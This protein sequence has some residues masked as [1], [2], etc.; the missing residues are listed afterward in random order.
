MPTNQELLQKREK[1]V[2]RGVVTAFPIFADKAQN[3]EIWDVEGKR[4]IDFA[5]GIGVMNTGHRHPKVLEAIASQ[6]QKILHAAFQVMGY[7][8]YIQLA[9]KLNSL[10]PISGEKKSIFFSTGAE[11]CEN[12][13]KIAR[14]ATKR[15]GMISFTGGFH[16]RT[17]MAMALTGKVVPYKKNM[18]PM[19]GDVFHVPFPIPY[20]GTTEKDSLKAL[21]NLFKADIEPERVA[22]I[23]IEP[24]QGEGGFYIAS[25]SFLKEL[26]KVCDTHGILLISDE[27]Q[28]GFARTGK[29]F[30]IEHSGVEPDLIT[31]AKSLAGGLPLSGV[32]GKA[33]IM[34]A[35]EPGGLGGTYGGNPVACAAALAIIDLIQEEK[36][37]E[38]SLKIGE[39]IKTRI[40][41]IA[42]HNPIIG[43]VRGL[44]GMVAFEV[45]ESQTPPTPSM[46]LAKKITTKALE[47]GLI[48]LS[49]GV[50]GN[51]IRILVPIT[52]E[53][54]TLE[55]AL[56]ILENTLETV[57]GEL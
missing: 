46:N 56:G 39:I 9:E 18:G 1:N 10:A 34:D 28:S 21:E 24:V 5:G 57:R 45:V 11:A 38:R 13:V 52:I 42:N 4:Y 40:Q 26:R 15:T 23:V 49:C 54:Q 33:S 43:E 2:P 22:A 48:L 32:I 8:V 51:V 55:E 25:P 30:A 47:N 29:F 7:E 17:F 36:I 44:G 14:S 27:I 19:P 6:T 50:Y 16:G 12:A 37:L 41:K 3:A 35:V 53:D 31:T 20:Y